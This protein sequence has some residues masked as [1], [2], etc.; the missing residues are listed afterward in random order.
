MRISRWLLWLSLGCG[1][2]SVGEGQSFDVQKLHGG[3]IWLDFRPRPTSVPNAAVSRRLF[4]E[5][6]R[7]M[8]TW[9]PV[10]QVDFTNAYAYQGGLRVPSELQQNGERFFRFRTTETAHY[11]TDNAG[12]YLGLEGLFTSALLDRYFLIQK[13]SWTCTRRDPMWRSSL[14][15]DHC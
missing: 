11:T 12:E 14:G 6:S 15:C 9:N 13:T 4:L 1:G 10:E 7:D 3:E 5:S 8:T 2:L